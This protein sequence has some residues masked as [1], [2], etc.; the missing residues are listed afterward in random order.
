[1]TL[2]P[3]LII[4]LAKLDSML[5]ALP[6][7]R[8]GKNRFIV[9]CMENNTKLIKNNKRINSGLHTHNCKSTLAHP[10]YIFLILTKSL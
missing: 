9:L 8:G 3:V 1:M 2:L 4:M 5:G 6:I 10:V 7:N